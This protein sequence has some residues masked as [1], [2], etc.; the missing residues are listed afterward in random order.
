MKDP[1]LPDPVAL[2]RRDLERKGFFPEI[3]FSEDTIFTVEDAS[4]VVGAP[5]ERILKSLVFFA[6]GRPL[7]AL[8]CGNNRVDLKKIRTLGGTGKVRMASPDF[9]LQ[10]SGFSFGGIPPVGYPEPV[11]AFLDEDLFLHPVVWAAA[12]TDRAFFPVSPEDLLR[13]TCGKRC[14]IKK[15]EKES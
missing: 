14:D 11:Q 9:V 15:G 2:V 3:T 8:M 4:R 1:A 12:G 13:L 5:P 10:W 6:D 7:L